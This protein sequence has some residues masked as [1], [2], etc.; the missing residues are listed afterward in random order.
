MTVSI[1]RLFLSI[2]AQI[3]SFLYASNFSQKAMVTED[4]KVQME[5]ALTA[6][7]GSSPISL[8]I[9]YEIVAVGVAIKISAGKY[10]CV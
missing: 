7:S 6:K 5:M 2:R 1:R 10:S 9:T 8:A 4:S 3:F